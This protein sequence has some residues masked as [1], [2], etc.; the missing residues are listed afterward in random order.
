MKLLTGIM[1][2]NKIFLLPFLIIILNELCFSQEMLT[3]EDAVS[4]ALKN[5]FSIS[6]ARNESKIAENNS[7]PGNAGLL[8]TLDAV[9]QKT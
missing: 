9:R 5:N 8:P 2:I 4:I 3:L 6:I 7:T 1:K